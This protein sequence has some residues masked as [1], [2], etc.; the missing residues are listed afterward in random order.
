MDPEIDLRSDLATLLV[1]EPPLPPAAERLRA[2]R[3]RQARRRTLTGLGSVALVG[4]LGAGYGVASGGTSSTT[5]PAT[6]SS[7]G[8]PTPP[9]PSPTV[10]TEYDWPEGPEDL[11]AIR[12]FTVDHATGEVSPAPGVQIVDTIVQVARAEAGAVAVAVRRGDQE[13]W[14]R[15]TWGEPGSRGAESDTRGTPEDADSFAAWA[16]ELERLA[17][18]PG[19]DDLPEPPITWDRYGVWTLADGVTLVDQIEDPF[20]LPAPY[21]SAALTV[22]D[23]HGVADWVITPSSG[24]SMPHTGPD[25]L[26]ALVDAEQGPSMSVKGP[27]PHLVES[28]PHSMPVVVDG[29]EV[30]RTVENPL[31]VEEPRRSVAYELD[32]GQRTWWLLWERGPSGMLIAE[33]TRVAGDGYDDLDA[34]LADQK[35]R[36]EW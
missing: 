30:L 29:V 22:R 7:D 23:E 20:D 5:T 4:V 13:H 2:G 36:T 16:A 19:R 28:G 14:Y 18:L 21:T 34:W 11:A 25:S 27:M 24:R 6:S 32:D 10:V 15:V 35:A 12:G 1:D 26:Q 31:D 8:A 17:A 33:T 3:R 9:T